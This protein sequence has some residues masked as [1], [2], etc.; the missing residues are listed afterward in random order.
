MTHSNSQPHS[1][2]APNTQQLGY[3]ERIV[4][5]LVLVAIAGFY[6]FY[7]FQHA[8]NVPLAD[9]I[10][11]VLKPLLEVR[12]AD[13]F[14]AGLDSLYAQHTDHRTIASRLVYAVSYFVSGEIDFRTL[15]I[16]A[17]LALPLLLVTLYFMAESSPR[18][19]LLLVP[20]ALIVLQLRA[21]GITFWVMSSFAYF[22]VFLYGFLSILLLHKANP[23]R[24][25]GSA[26]FAALASFTLASGQMVWLI[27]LASLMQ[28]V[29]LRKSLPRHYLIAW[30]LSAIAILV[31][32]RV[33]QVERISPSILL[34]LFFDQPGHYVLYTLTLLGNTVSES[35]VL[36]AASTGGLLLIGL[37]ACT[38]A[39]W[40]KAD[41]RLELCCWFIVLSVATMVLG[42][43]FTSVDYGLSSRYSFPSVLLCATAWILASVRLQ[44][45]QWRVLLPALLI[46]MTFNIHSFGAY[47]QALQPYMDK[48]VEDFNRG[49][50]RAFGFPAKE[51]NNIVNEAI[52]EGLYT[53]P[54]RPMPPAEVALGRAAQAN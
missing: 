13:S 45:T 47:S 26:F 11:D 18:R 41:L 29:F 8:I 51:T 30:L 43:G 21:Y 19:L 32:W 12:H 14:S 7:L 6:F 3:W 40:R 20:A 27:G 34:Q 35:S 17:N 37:S 52:K 23:L 16:V 54:S 28:Q 49:Y 53:P 25:A 46:A 33:G 10:Y 44:L 2:D 50:Y 31:L 24:F 39:R 9:D 22:Y 15:N 4:C 5:S 36:A 48:R 42:R 38:L 1:T